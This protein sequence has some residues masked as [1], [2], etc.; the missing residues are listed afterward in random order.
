MRWGQKQSSEASSATTGT[1]GEGSSAMPKERGMRPKERWPSQPH[2]RCL[3]SSFTNWSEQ[4]LLVP[5]HER[6][7]QLVA[8][9]PQGGRQ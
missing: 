4:V 2:L 9:A 6:T 5:P 8:R 7:C 1:S 3:Q